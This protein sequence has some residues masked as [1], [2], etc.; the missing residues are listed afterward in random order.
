ATQVSGRLAMATVHTIRPASGCAMP[1]NGAAAARPPGSARLYT[2]RGRRPDATPTRSLAC[3][4]FARQLQRNRQF[5]HRY[6]VW[7]ASGS[8]FEVRDTAG[9]EASLF[10][11]LFLRHA[12]GNPERAQQDSKRRY[13][14]RRVR[15]AQTATEPAPR[16]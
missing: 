2:R 9:A 16:E 6:L 14:P 5:A 10:R 8:A 13:R 1:A 15:G 3:V 4:R 12:A 11:E 7:V